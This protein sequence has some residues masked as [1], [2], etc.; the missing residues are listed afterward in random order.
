MSRWPD[1]PSEINS[2]LVYGVFQ[3]RGGW[4]QR[5]QGSALASVDPHTREVRLLEY[6]SRDSYDL[7]INDF[8][9]KV[10]ST[11]VSVAVYE[12]EDFEF[13]INEEDVDQVRLAWTKFKSKKL[14][15]HVVKTSRPTGKKSRPT[16]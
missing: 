9:F 6:M 2:N 11:N 3:V 4:S 14:K 8:N 12:G 13:E 1:L 5:L 16:M 10:Y 15:E 7:G